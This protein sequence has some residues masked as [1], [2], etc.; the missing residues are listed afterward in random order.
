M[1]HSDPVFYIP[2]GVPYQRIARLCS[3]R[4]QP[5]PKDPSRL[6][7]TT[8][9]DSL[10]QAMA[11][12]MGNRDRQERTYDSKQEPI[13]EVHHCAFFDGSKKTAGHKPA[14]LVLMRPNNG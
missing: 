5:L 4:I 7:H 9:M 11:P 8:A 10:K 2:Q 13:S 1:H 3:L 14:G 6:A 12:Q